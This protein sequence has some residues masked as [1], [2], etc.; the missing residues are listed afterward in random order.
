M[1]EWL[2]KRL[3]MRKKKVIKARLLYRPERGWGRG[4]ELEALKDD[5]ALMQFY[6][7]PI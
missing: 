5:W 6:S 2:K 4:L 7:F 3:I 1:S